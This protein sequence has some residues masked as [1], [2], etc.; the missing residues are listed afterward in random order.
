MGDILPF[1]EYR[2]DLSDL[3]AAFT[4]SIMNVVPRADGYGPLPSISLLTST[5]P[6]QCCGAF[7][8]R[9]PD[10]SIS[11]F[12]ATATDLYLL[13]NTTWTWANVSKTGS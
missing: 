7:Y 3:N 4:S 11:V 2:P 13:N 5:L 9:N 6:S 12:G 10:G 1:G 8:A